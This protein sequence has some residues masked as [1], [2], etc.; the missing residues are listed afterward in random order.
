MGVEALKEAPCEAASLEEQARLNE[1]ELRLLEESSL[2]FLSSL[3]VDHVVAPWSGGK[4]STAA[5]LLAFKAF[6]RRRVH[7]LF[8]DT[9]VE[10]RE[11]YEYVE[12]LSRQLGFSYVKARAG[13]REA[14]KAGRGLPTHGDRWCTAMKVEAAERYVAQ[15]SRDGRVLVVVGDREA[16]SE[17]R[18]RRPALINHGGYLEAAPIKPW[19]AIHVQLYLALQGVPANPMYELGFFRLGCYVCPALQSWELKIALARPELAYLKHDELFKAL[20]AQR[21]AK[22]A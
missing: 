11:T 12:S 3:D 17:A 2:S 1:A 6:G 4:D 16:E 15:L 9:G 18:L 10:F 14:L 22:P 8:L 7:P 5:L 19:G 20:L 21:L 13:V